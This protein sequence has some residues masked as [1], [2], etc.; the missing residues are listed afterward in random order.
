MDYLLTSDAQQLRLQLNNPYQDTW[1]LIDYPGF[2]MAKDS[3]APMPGP[4]TPGQDQLWRIPTT[5]DAKEFTDFF[6]AWKTV[7]G[8]ALYRGIAGCHF[9]WPRMRQDGTLESEGKNDIPMATMGNKQKTCWLPS[10]WDY[11]TAQGVSVSCLSEAKEP[12]MNYLKLMHSTTVNVARPCRFPV[13]IVLKV[14]VRLHG[15]IPV[16]W[17]NAC[18]TVFKGPLNPSQ[19][20]VHEVAWLVPNGLDFTATTMRPQDLFPERPW[21][22]K[23]KDW[24]VEWRTSNPRNDDWLK[25]SAVH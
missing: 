11:G 5:R 7:T 12:V 10:A 23:S 16:C 25:Q 15:A 20:S 13:G 24:F 1:S 3:I 6:N 9:S 19:Y 14:P 2:F 17:L 4:P 21:E 22:P 18:E 8:A